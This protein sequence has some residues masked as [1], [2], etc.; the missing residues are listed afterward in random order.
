MASLTKHLS[1][2]AGTA[3]AWVFHSVSAVVSD[4]FNIS[5]VTDVGTGDFDPQFS[6]SMA[7]SDYAVSI[8]CDTTGAVTRTAWVVGRAASS[9]DLMSGLTSSASSSESA[10]DG[11]HSAVFGDLA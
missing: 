5:S 4:S 2:E 7:N 11:I 9:Y 8:G 1:H 3:K 10:I 6:N